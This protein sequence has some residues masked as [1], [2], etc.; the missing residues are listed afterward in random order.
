MTGYVPGTKLVK[1]VR[2]KYKIT[3]QIYRPLLIHLLPS[4]P[5]PT[6]VFRKLLIALFPS[7]DNIR[8]TLLSV[9]LVIYWRFTASV[10]DDVCLFRS[11]TNLTSLLISASCWGDLSVVSNRIGMKFQECCSLFNFRQM[12]HID[13]RLTESDFRFDVTLSRWQ[14]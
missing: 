3:T 12:K 4:R 7:R 11:G 13:D 8:S 10:Y 6:I 14:S 9:S 1:Y 2:Q 5:I